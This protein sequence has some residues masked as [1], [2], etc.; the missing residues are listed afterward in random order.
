[1]ICGFQWMGLNGNERKPVLDSFFFVFLQPATNPPKRNRCRWNLECDN[2]SLPR[3]SP[4][5]RGEPV[6][7]HSGLFF[8]LCVSVCKPAMKTPRVN[9]CGCHS[10][11]CVCVCLFP[12]Q[13]ANKPTDTDALQN[14]CVS[15]QPVSEFCFSFSFLSFPSLNG[16]ITIGFH[17]FEHPPY[18]HLPDHFTSTCLRHPAG[19]RRRAT[20]R[21]SLSPRLPVCPLSY[22]RQRTKGQ[23][24]DGSSV[25]GFLCV[26]VSI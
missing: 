9:Q 17:R 5:P 7:I 6:T 16:G 4:I 26:R 21:R 3:W 13:T 18:P 14:S 23:R 15:C 22:W 19:F 2:V 11:F 24:C 20:G 12:H 25:H 8:S 10:D 1:M